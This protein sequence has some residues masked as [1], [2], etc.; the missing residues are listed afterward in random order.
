MAPFLTGIFLVLVVTV[1]GLLYVVVTD[2]RGFR[3]FVAGMKTEPLTQ[4]LVTELE[5]HPEHWTQTV[6]T[7]YHTSGIELWTAN[8][9]DYCRVYS[10]KTVE[11]TESQQKRIWAAYQKSGKSYSQKNCDQEAIDRVLSLLK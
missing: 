7:L 6:H 3:E 2:R 4:K 9:Q 11:F 8:G 10:P 1:A 5:T